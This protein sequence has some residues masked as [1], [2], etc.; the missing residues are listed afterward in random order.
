[1]PLPLHRDAR[2]LFGD[3]LLGFAGDRP[4]TTDGLGLFVLDRD[5]GRVLNRIAAPGAQTTVV[6]S[7]DDDLLVVWHR[8]GEVEDADKTPCGLAAY[9]P[10]RLRGVWRH[11]ACDFLD[12]ADDRRLAVARAG[13]GLLLLAALHRDLASDTD[14]PTALV[15][16]AAAS[17]QPVWRLD[18]PPRVGAVVGGGARFYLAARDTVWALDPGTGRTLWRSPRATGAD[19]AHASDPDLPVAL[20]TAAAGDD[21]FVA[22][23]N[24]VGRFDGAAGAPRWQRSLPGAGAIVDLVE[25]QGTLFAVSYR[26]GFEGSLVALDAVTGAIRWA[27]EVW[28]PAIIGAVPEGLLVTCTVDGLDHWLSVL[29]PADGAALAQIDLGE[30]FSGPSVI[31]GADGYLVARRGEGLTGLRLRA[32][33][34]DASP[35]MARLAGAVEICYRRACFRRAGLDVRVTGAEP[36][37]KAETVVT[38]AG[39]RF[40]FPLRRGR[41][42]TALVDKANFRLIEEPLTREALARDSS[43]RNLAGEVRCYGNAPST[44]VATRDGETVQVVLR[45]DCRIQVPD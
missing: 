17:G 19:P 45:I 36:G 8:P 9:D 31:A 20:T 38:D 15:A 12:R 35:A 28:Q 34:E 40:T 10:R 44:I 33:A 32:G 42:V 27:R 3:R 4:A 16:V 41:L 14:G 13:K 26:D 11:K 25:R 22:A 37:A 23:G 5:R 43:L 7:G 24:T 21:L 29:G 2:V 30:S 1:M 39:G 18:G 6:R